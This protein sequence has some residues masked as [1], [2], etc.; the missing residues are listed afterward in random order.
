[1]YIDTWSSVKRPMQRKL[2]DEDGDKLRDMAEMDASVYDEYLWSEKELFTVTTSD[3]WTLDCSMM[4]PAN[5]DPSKKYPVFFDVYGGPGTQAVRNSWPSTMQ[6]WYCSEGF[7]VIQADNRGSSARGTVFKHAV[8][9]QLGKWEVNDY[10]EVAKYLGTL[11]YVDAGRIGIWGWSYGGYMAAL[12]MLQGADY[13]HTGV[14]IAPLTDWSL[15]DTIYAERF[16]QRPED[17]PDG[18]KVGSCLEY[19]DKLKGNL[20]IIHG[21]MDDNVHVQNTMKLIDQLEEAGKQFDMRI[22]PNGD[23]G[24]AGG[25]K[26]RLGLFQYYMD[27]MKEHLIGG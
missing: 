18:Y 20:L 19:A 21:A 6:Q 17:N 1:M 2:F 9:K 16:M 10:V 4:K 11:P 22:Y 7:I 13:F 3:G 5:F 26:S 8:Y 24:V 12:T 14:A 25:F 27:Y 15:Y 23:H